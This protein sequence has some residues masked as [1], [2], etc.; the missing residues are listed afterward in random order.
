MTINSESLV[1]VV[2]TRKDG[3][4]IIWTYVPYIPVEA[5]RHATPW[6]TV[7]RW[8]YDGFP[9][10]GMPRTDENQLMLVLEVA[11]G[12]IERP[13]F[14][15]EVYRRVGA[16]LR[17]FVYYIA[18]RDRFLEEFNAHVAGK[19]RFPIEIKFYKDETWSELRDLIDD[20]SAISG[21]S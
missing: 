19:P 5:T 20:F 12:C 2:E 18:N 16:G 14:C 10:N 8:E 4:P 21:A 7:V 17:E 6:L 1:R 3:L 9:D 13:E 15:V 11:L